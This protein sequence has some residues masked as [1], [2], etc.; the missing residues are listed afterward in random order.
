[1]QEYEEHRDWE[2]QFNKKYTRKMP[3]FDKKP[4]AVKLNT[5]AIIREE[6]LLQQK[7]KKEEQ[8]LKD[9]EMNLWDDTEYNRWVEENRKTE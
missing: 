2:L 9:Y 6:A 3:N 8:V 1:M 4:A 7:E 5:A